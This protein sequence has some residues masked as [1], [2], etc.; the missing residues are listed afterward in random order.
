L[1]G[2]SKWDGDARSSL[3]QFKKRKG[4]YPNQDLLVAE[5]DPGIHFKI[6]PWRKFRTSETFD[7]I[8]FSRSPNFTSPESDKLIPVIEAYMRQI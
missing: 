5:R 4:E 2:L 7:Y 1:K 8:A 6:V 3:I